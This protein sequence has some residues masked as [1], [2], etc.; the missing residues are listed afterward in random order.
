MAIGDIARDVKG[1]DEACRH[2]ADDEKATEIYL[3]EVFRVQEKVGNAQVFA[4]ATGDHSKQDDPAQDQHVV[5]FDVVQ[6]Q[7]CRKRVNK[8]WN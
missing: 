7:L 3:V 2:H 1:R 4:K 5:A 6:E 8:P